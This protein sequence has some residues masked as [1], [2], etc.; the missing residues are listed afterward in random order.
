MKR[1]RALVSPHAS[2]AHRADIAQ[3]YGSAKV[4]TAADWIDFVVCPYWEN[5]RRPE[6][7][8]AECADCGRAI[9]YM[10]WAPP[11]PPKI[12]V[13]CLDVRAAAP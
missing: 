4:A 2:E 1:I 8:R 7:L 10:P 6:S 11:G 9:S 5:R 3:L 12:C 13:R